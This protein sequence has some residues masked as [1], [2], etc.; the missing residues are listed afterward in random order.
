LWFR[1]TAGTPTVNS[2]AT[3]IG[4]N[5]GTNPTDPADDV[6]IHRIEPQQ[7]KQAGT[8]VGVVLPLTGVRANLSGST[9]YYLT[10]NIVWTGTGT[11]LLYGKI[12]ARS[13]TVPVPN[14]PNPLVA[15]RWYQRA[16]NIYG[17]YTYEE[18]P[19]SYEWWVRRS[20]PATE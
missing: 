5:P 13:Q 19:Q 20:P 8:T 11:I 17:R 4:P 18:T 15:G 6:G 7:A 12:S 14:Q 2:I 3:V 9:A 16:G 1:V 10:A